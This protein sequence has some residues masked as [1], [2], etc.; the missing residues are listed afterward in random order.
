M[1][2]CDTIRF[3]VTRSGDDHVRSGSVAKGRDLLPAEDIDPARL[4]GALQVT[5]A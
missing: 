2:F 3:R 4:D 5:E 1:Y